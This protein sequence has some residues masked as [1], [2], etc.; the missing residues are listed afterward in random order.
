[1]IIKDKRFI[2]AKGALSIAFRCLTDN[3]SYRDNSCKGDSFIEDLSNFC[4]A[5]N[6]IVYDPERT[7]GFVIQSK[8]W[9]DQWYAGFLNEIER[10]KETDNSFR[11]PEALEN[12]IIK[13]YMFLC[14]RTEEDVQKAFSYSWT[15]KN[16]YSYETIWITENMLKTTSKMLPRYIPQYLTD[17]LHPKEVKKLNLGNNRIAREIMER[18]R[19]AWRIRR[20]AVEKGFAVDNYIGEKK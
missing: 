8:K 17:F 20:L 4:G 12:V 6:A 9:L 7:D 19:E 14:S 11:Y 10:M 5:W 18:I 16:G 3:K 15:V 1:M 2:K 13:T